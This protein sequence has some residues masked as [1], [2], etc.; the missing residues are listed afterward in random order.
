MFFDGRKELSDS[1]KR[2]MADSCDAISFENRDGISA[3]SKIIQSGFYQKVF[4]A[5]TLDIWPALIRRIRK[6][7]RRIPGSDCE[8]EG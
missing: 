1:Q 6:Y 7:R 4:K 3:V 8:K 5:D 2:W